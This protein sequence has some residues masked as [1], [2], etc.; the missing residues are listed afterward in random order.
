MDGLG[1]RGCVGVWAGSFLLIF[2]KY[3]STPHI[4]THHIG[5]RETYAHG[6]KPFFFERQLFL[7]Y[8]QSQE[9]LNV[10]IAI[11]TIDDGALKSMNLAWEMRKAK[12]KE[13]LEQHGEAANRKWVED[14]EIPDEPGASAPPRGAVQG[15]QHTISKEKANRKK[16]NWH[17]NRVRDMD[18]A[19]YADQPVQA[20]SRGIA[21]QGG[22]RCEIVLQNQREATYVANVCH[23]RGK[24][25]SRVGLH[26]QPSNPRETSICHV[27]GK[28]VGCATNVAKACLA[29]VLHKTPNVRQAFATYV[30]NV[31]HVSG[32]CLSHIGVAC[33]TTRDTHCHVRGKRLPRT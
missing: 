12:L 9:W 6:R 3:K 1:D 14:S 17:R 11:G 2:Y 26:T 10:L 22:G 28:S 18:A 15:I 21:R 16:L 8:S 32:K 20:E 31:C 29:L 24:C 13:F 4:Q 25:L 27:S 23:V 30:A 7:L 5:E 19:W 33:K